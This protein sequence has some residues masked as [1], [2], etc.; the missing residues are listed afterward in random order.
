MD[1]INKR[2]RILKLLK[3]SKLSNSYLVNDM[4]KNVKY[5]QLNLLNNDYI[6]KKLI[7]YYTENYTSLTNINNSNIVSCKSFGRIH[8][9]DNKKLTEGLYFY[10]NEYIENNYDLSH[11]IPN[12][13]IR[14]KLDLFVS[15]CSALNYLHLRGLIYNEVNPSNILINKS[16]NKLTVKLKDIATTELE[17]Y[18][19]WTN[20]NYN[21][22][23]KA[24]ELSE[25]MPPTVLSDIYSLGMLLLTLNIDNKELQ[26]LANKMI[27]VS[28][29]NRCSKITD[30]VNEINKIFNTDYKC[31]L[32]EDIEVLN[33]NTKITGRNYEISQ[34]LDAYKKVAYYD[35]NKKFILIHGDLG[36]GKTRLLKEICHKL[37][38][39]GANVFSSFSLNNYDGLN[40]K[41]LI[42]ILK[43][44]ISECDPKDIEPYESEL[45][46][47]LPD[48]GINKKI[49]PSEPLKGS[50]E[51]FRIIN[52]IINLFNEF[53][54]D[55][56]TVFIFD[57]LNMADAISI[58]F[59]EHVYLKKD[60]NKKVIFICSYSDENLILNKKLSNF[61]NNVSLNPNVLNL[62]LHNLDEVETGEMIKNIL[63]I[64]Y[65][66]VNF[67]KAIFKKTYG[68]P[69]FVEESIKNLFAKKILYVDGDSGIWQT[70][71]N[72]KNYIDL[73]IPSSMEQAIS[74]Q[75]K[76][77]DSQSMDVLKVVSIFYKGVSLNNILKLLPFT[78]SYET[79]LIQNL[80][81]RGI[82]CEKIDDSGVVYDFYN[83]LLKDSIYSK[84]DSDYK[85]TMHENAAKILENSTYD[86][87]ENREELIYHLEKAKKN[88]KVI[89]YYTENANKML[90]LNNRQ[91]A[92][93]Y[94]LKSLSLITDNKKLDCKLELY[95]KIANI[96]SEDSNTDSAIKYYNIA[97]DLAKKLNDIYNKIYICTNLGNIYFINKNLIEKGMYYINM[98]E[99]MLSSNYYKNLYLEFNAVKCNIFYSL[100]KYEEMQKICD[101]CIP[102]CEDEFPII[103]GKLYNLLGNFFTYNSQMETALQSYN[104]AL[105]LFKM[106]DYKKGIVFI[107]NNLGALYGDFYQDITTSIDYFKQAL[108]ICQENNMM[109]GTMYALSNLGESYLSLFDY[110]TSLKYFKSSYEKS[111]IDDYNNNNLYNVTYLILVYAK[112]N[113]YKNAFKY[114]YISIE[115]I[116]SIPHV[117]EDYSTFNY[118]YAEFFYVLGD[119]DKASEFLNISIN[120]DVPS[121]KQTYD[122]L[123]L[124]EKI[125]I[126]NAFKINKKANDFDLNKII[127]IVNNYSQITDKINAICEICLLF[128][129]N[130]HIKLSKELFQNIQAIDISSIPDRLKSK[131]LYLR[132]TLLNPN[133]ELELLDEAANIA[134]KNQQYLLSLKIKVRQGQLFLNSKNYFYSVNYYL[135]ACEIIRSLTIQL[136]Q[137][138]R[139]WFV[140]NSKHT[141]PFT[142]LELI[143][144]SVIDKNTTLFENVN[145]TEVSNEVELEQLLSYHNLRDVLNNKQIIT[146]A[147]KVFSNYS[148]CKITT[149]EDLLS[150]LSSDAYS[151]LKLIAKYLSNLTLASDC[152]IVIEDDTKNLYS[153][154]SSDGSKDISDIKHIINNVKVSKVAYLNAENY[155]SAENLCNF[156]YSS[157]SNSVICLP[158]LMDEKYTKATIYKNRKI[159]NHSNIVKGYVYLSSE[160]ILNNFNEESIKQCKKIINLLG[161]TIE[162]YQLKIS[163][164]IDK[165]TGALTRKY[166]EIQLS[167]QIEHCYENN[168]FF[169]IIMFDLDH[170]KSVNDRYGHQTGDEVLEKVSKIVLNS[171]RKDDALGRY[172]GEEFIIILPHT[173]KEDAFIVAEKLRIKIAN[174]NILGTKQ[175]VTISLGIS[176]YP[177]HSQWKE[178]II[179]KADQALYMSKE[180]GR[181]H[182]EIWNEDFSKTKLQTNKLSGIISGN[183]AND[184]RNVQVILELLDLIKSKSSKRD[185]IYHLL[186]RIIEITESN[187]GIVLIYK[188]NKVTKKYSRK[189]FN[190]G[191]IDSCTFS[192]KITNSVLESSQGMFMI[193]WDEIAEYDPLTGV[194][195]WNSVAAVPLINSGTVKGI[196]YLSV[197]INMKEFSFNDFNFI[198]FLAD[199]CTAII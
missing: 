189:A 146:S 149:T 1:L 133:N 141:K 180:R 158:I 90:L 39:S 21:L 60:A 195:Q 25:G 156:Q 6:N 46:K 27:D 165:L 118:I 92:I 131:I 167:N 31:L 155:L 144:N 168:D 163:S 55:K 11:N 13:S 197:P 119:L 96:Y 54:N 72:F 45:I 8:S 7:D 48:I 147:Q 113:D 106:I 157:F 140:N 79:N 37:K 150:N 94:Y 185:K 175:P 43:K 172:G 34:I 122:E 132:A 139:I 56:P 51:N 66:P 129:K 117:G 191:W 53:I 114:F 196:L 24:P 44:L 58:E 77:L 86:S 91:G 105:E 193:D 183:T 173:N 80:V 194:P 116:K 84:L 142:M 123:I 17:K 164:S 47:I 125:A 145:D 104:K 103:K 181:N 108:K 127:D 93:T 10:T 135:E 69:L 143:K 176:S 22:S 159:D 20:A 67:A 26:N 199:I 62:W 111:L 190:D 99:S 71:Y 110:N 169:S 18:D 81:S 102:L 177:E 160:K 32:K 16:D 49:T 57:N 109:Y 152:R 121:T 78:F 137:E 182:S 23:F 50:S 162:N 120:S 171:I 65:V 124:R 107:Y 68:N 64:F 28:I 136:P 33:F 174:A 100:G 30:I 61:I 74:N 41:A 98:S 126:S 170:F 134:N 2:Y 87:F 38:V 19:Y 198:S 42:D 12:L 59:I 76:E 184:S 5:I 82:L 130:D 15:I 97:L 138:Y 148:S 83:K 36:V 52:A 186:G 9:I 29:D 4:L 63:D 128:Q 192:E 85:I 179:R 187:T 166:L 3:Q 14:K 35:E 112:I 178:D 70:E 153:I 75:I 73:P 101:H 95:V 89:L 154:V 151:N 188:N 40:N 88:D 161:F 115:K